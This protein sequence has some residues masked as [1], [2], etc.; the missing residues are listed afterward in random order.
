MTKTHKK[1]ITFCLLILFLCVVG[2]SMFFLFSKNKKSNNEDSTIKD[3]KEINEDEE[4]SEYREIRID[5][6]NGLMI[7]SIGSYSGAYYEDGTD[8]NVKDIIA[9]EVTNNGSKEVQYCEI[10]ISDDVDEAN[11]S[12]STLKPNETVIVLENTKKKFIDKNEYTTGEV[13]NLAFFSESTSLHDEMLQIQGLDGTLNVT[14]ISKKDIPSDIYIYYKNY[15]DE[16]FYGG[17]TYRT[18]VSGGLKF[19]EV[20]Q[21]TASHFL[22][23]S[24]KIV[25]VDIVGQ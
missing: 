19:E 2:V 9:I 4:H 25:F 14:N 6:E 24:S 8:E 22:P 5:L 12:L 17:I 1:I 13:H 20:R 7:S 3:D 16:K 11:F 10:S 21:I 18:K 15:I 23:E